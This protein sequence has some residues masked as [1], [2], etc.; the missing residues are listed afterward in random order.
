MAAILVVDDEKNIRAHLATYLGSLGHRVETA[1]DGAQ[2]LAL[3][4]R[5]AARGR[6][7]RR[8]HGGHGRHGAAAR[9]PSPAARGGGGADDRLCHRRR[10]GR[11]HACGRLRLPG[12]ALLARRGGAAARARA[13]GAR[14]CGGRTAGCARAVEEPALLESASPAMQ[15]VLATARQVAG[16]D[17]TRAADR[18]ERHREERA[19]RPPSIAGATRRTGPFVTI[20]CTTLAEHLLESELFGHVRGA[21]TGAWKD[22]PGRLEAARGGTVFLDEVGELSPEL[23]AK[24]LRFLEERRFERV[25]GARDARGRRPHRG[26]HQPRPGGG[27]GRRPLPRGPVL[28]PERGRAPAA[29]A[30]RAPRGPA[31]ARRHAP[32]PA[33]RPPRARRC[34]RSTRPRALRSAPTRGRATSASW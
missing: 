31:G 21:F 10:R 13:R 14:R 20:A 1:D 2:A 16:S 27:G 30:A 33:V 3:L 6:V 24:L 11:G 28:P 9:G 4:D 23:Q 8:A 26:R 15:R 29:R 32:R 7:L 18:R 17:V 34:W 5:L 19:R 25:G 12:E 22:K